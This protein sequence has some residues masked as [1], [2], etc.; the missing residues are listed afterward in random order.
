MIET[1]E[2]QPTREKVLSIGRKLFADASAAYP[3]SVTAQAVFIAKECKS[4]SID[5]QVIMD[6]LLDDQDSIWLLT[7]AAKNAHSKSD[8]YIMRVSEDIVTNILEMDF[9]VAVDCMQVPSDQLQ[10][11]L[12]AYPRFQDG[13]DVRIREAKY[14]A[15]AKEVTGK[16][17]DS[18][19]RQ[20][21]VKWSSDR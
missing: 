16:Q 14:Q 12:E 15:F 21:N 9:A 17:L 5:P 3:A 10:E 7:N 2:F 20:G 1:R 6:H 11:I 18:F 4:Q 8:K 19:Y 13:Q